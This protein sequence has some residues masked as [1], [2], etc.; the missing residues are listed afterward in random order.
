M[1]VSKGDKILAVDSD[2][3]AI[4][5]TGGKVVATRLCSSANEDPKYQTKLLWPPVWCPGDQP[6]LGLHSLVAGA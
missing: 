4:V 1:A 2:S 5:K 6:I 3:V